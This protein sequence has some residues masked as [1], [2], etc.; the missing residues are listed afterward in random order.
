LLTLA[1][2]AQ[3]GEFLVYR[4]V[5][6]DGGV[7]ATTSRFYAIAAAP[8]L[9]RDDA[10]PFRFIRYRDLVTTAGA[11]ATLTAGGLV[12]LV[13]D[14]AP[15]PAEQAALRSLIADHYKLA[16]ADAI[17]L[18]AL[19]IERGRA[20]L[21]YGG[22]GTPTAF[23][24]AQDV[25]IAGSARVCFAMPV[26]QDGAGLLAGA[27]DR[28]VAVLFANLQIELEYVLDGIS[29]HVWCDAERAY[30]VASSLAATGATSTAD[31]LR[32]RLMSSHAAGI[33]VQSATPLPP[34]Q[35]EKL[36]ELGQL[37]LAT[38]L[39]PALVPPPAAAS[40]QPPA[41]HSVT[42][43]ERLALNA[44]FTMSYPATAK[45]VIDGPLRIELTADQRATAELDVSL[46]PDRFV[47]EA[48]AVCPIDFAGGLV[49]DVHIHVVYDA[50][51]ANGAALHRETDFALRAGSTHQVFRFDA[52]PTQRS[53]SWRATVTY[54]DGTVL[55][56]PARTTDETVLVIEQGQLGVMAVAVRLVDAPLSLLAHAIVDLQLPSKGIEHQVVLDGSNPESVWQIAVGAG[57]PGPYRYAVTWVLTDGRRL[58]QDPR[59]TSELRVFLSAPPEALA[60]NSVMAVAAADFT[61][62]AQLVVEL[63]PL[64]PPDAEHAILRFTEAGVP[65][66]WTF[67]VA[68]PGTPLG[69]QARRTVIGRDGTTASFDYTTEDSPIL[70]V[71]DVSRFEVQLIARL[72]DLGGAYKVALVTLASDD[73]TPPVQDTL[74]ISNRD[75]EPTWRF[76]VADPT[77]HHYRVQFTLV[78]RDGT[79][80]DCNWVDADE[81]IFV[82]RL[83]AT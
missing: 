74:T 16:N 23:G 71:R 29:L 80:R 33:D 65:Q 19:E 60:T 22:D 78:A 38:A 51:T 63:R 25:A 7:R 82:L 49:S 12:T 55:E 46:A 64:A 11:P 3:L 35:A 81:A 70:V 32:S 5:R 56:L 1:D 18:A 20:Q 59:D 8:R 24:T 66:T 36:E 17:E 62:I 43:R 54:K 34:D 40:G 28:G 42:T 57:D 76:H 30:S 15:V 41:I 4:D 52:S 69:Y 77:K 72:L 53:Y 26:S 44:T 2:S 50:T 48:T 31:E 58:S 10:A 75:D 37:L 67:P 73:A 47:L 83:P 68:A 13:L 45:I 6:F 9:A 39:L 61:D 14:L 79:R 21:T 27:L